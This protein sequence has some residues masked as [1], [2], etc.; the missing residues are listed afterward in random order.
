MASPQIR[1]QTFGEF[2]QSSP[3]QRSAATRRVTL[4]GAV[5]NLV[6]SVLK[7]A[8]GVIAQS[9]SL[10]ADGVHSLSDLLTDGL[11]LF[12]AGHAHQEPDREHPY[13]HG[14]F[15]TAA[16]LGLGIFL[17]LVATGIIWDAVGRL[18]EPE[19][20]LQPGIMALY[21]AALSI[22][23]NEFLYR[24]TMVVARRFRSEMLRANAWHHRSDAMSSV[25]V[26]VGVGGTMAGLPYLDAIGAV[27]VGLMIGHI[28]W[29]LGSKAIQELVDAGLDEERL[30]KIRETILSVGGVQDIHMLR[31]RRLAGRASVDVHVLV[32]PWLSVSEGH[33]ISQM[34]TDRLLDDIE[35]VSDVTVHIDPEDDEVAT[36]CSGLP[37]RSEV[38]RRLALQWQGIPG[39]EGRERAILHYLDGR[40]RVEVIFPSGLFD[41]LEAARRL[42]TALQEGAKSLPEIA[43]IR[44]LV[45]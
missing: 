45:G 25:V 33:M 30:K 12:A 5:I 23:A 43:G 16:T 35:E 18:F 37:L 14:R 19:Q 24:Y 39:A 11:V 22:L 44:V 6:L 10:V 3:N 2:P 42:Q 4:I 15:E 17:A 28:A 20:L 9:Q 13:G 38:E 36:P 27:G 40:I 29:D 26:L 7:I 41:D 32:E 8:F 34:V 31:T 21:V 1:D